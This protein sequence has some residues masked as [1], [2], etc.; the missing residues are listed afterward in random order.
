MAYEKHAYLILA[1]DRPGQLLDLFRMLDHPRNDIYV[2]LDRK[3]SFRPEVFAGCCRHSG[4]HFI[5]PRIS[6]HWG[7]VSIMRAELAL[8]R[9]A[10]PGHYA[11]YHLLS[12]Q[13]LPIKSQDE[14]HAFF[15]AHPDREFLNLW[16]PK[17]HTQNRFRYFTLF[18]EGAGSFLPNLANNLV[19]GILMALHI[20]INRGIEFH[21]ASQWFSIT[22]PCAEYVLSQEA[23]LE[24]VFRHTNTV[25]EIFLA[26]V[27]CNSPFRE[28]LFDP[29]EHVQNKEIHNLASMRFI[30]WTRGKSVRHPWVFLS[31][32]RDLLESVPH[33]W[34]R[35]F[36]E[37]VDAGIIDYFSR[38]FRAMEAPSDSEKPAPEISVILPA[39]N[40]EPY[41]ARC[42]KSLQAQTFQDWEAICID[43]GSTDGTPQILDGFAAQDP[44]IQVIHQANAGVSA[45]RNRAVQLVRGRYCLLVD[46][47]DFLH[48]Q[49]MEICHRFAERD[50]SDLVAFTYDRAHRSELLRLRAKHLPEPET[51]PFKTYR[52]EDIRS[53]KA[54]DIFDWATEYAVMGLLRQKGEWT[55]KHCQPWRCLYR[56]DIIR[57]LRFPEGVI[58]EDLP[59]WGE[60]LLRV[61][62]AT[63]LN[64]PLYYYNPTPG[65]LI[66]GAELQKQVDSLR[67][68]IRLSEEHYKTHATPHQ[69]MIWEREFLSSFRKK[70]RKRERKLR[71]A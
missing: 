3:A 9:A 40:V 51:I 31:S 6:I 47:D 61:K 55:V 39:Y 56:T 71:K 68:V 53:R 66:I 59:W 10:V 27:I 22:H 28:R 70:L 30:D 45:A 29:T 46:S 52:I 42:L 38:K 17:S 2:H 64:L 32:D 19:K 33:L 20:R 15:D 58:F 21:F 16:K 26:T 41:I 11:F 54:E 8:L 34:A 23:W 50:R 37:R 24:K 67:E 60:V 35:K 43:D 25:D 48:P 44:R 62:A 1:H 57:D 5:E 7:G 65:S 63:V 13:D 69:Q 4:L 12:G 14:I 49:L 18:P 36:D